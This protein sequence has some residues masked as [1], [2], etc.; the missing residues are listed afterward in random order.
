MPALAGRT[1]A[2]LDTSEGTLVDIVLTDVSQAWQWITHWNPDKLIQLGSTR[3]GSDEIQEVWAE[4]CS[5]TSQE[6]KQAR[7]D[8]CTAEG[9]IRWQRMPDV[10][11]IHIGIHKMN[12]QL[13]IL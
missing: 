6:R 10:E 3:F 13:Y 2:K 12:L 8:M 4:L 7:N 5:M 9:K 11:T 1:R